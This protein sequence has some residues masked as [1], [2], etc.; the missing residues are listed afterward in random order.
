M[1]S[2]TTNSSI[3]HC[4]VINT[5]IDNADCGIVETLQTIL[6]GNFVYS[7]D[8]NEGGRSTWYGWNGNRWVNSD[9]P[10]R[11]AIMF[12]VEKYWNK[13]MEPWNTKYGGYEFEDANYKLWKRTKESA[14]NRVY[15]L[16]QAIGVNAVVTVAKS[17]ME[18]YSLEFDTNINLFGCENGVIDLD[19]ECFRPYRFDDYVSWSCGYDFKPLG[20][21]FKVLYIDKNE[22]KEK[23]VCEKD[24]TEGD[25]EEMKAV[26]NV[27][28]EIFP[29]KEMRDF[30]LFV[31]ATGLTGLA[32]EKFFVFNG[33]G[34]NGKGVTNEFM[35]S[36]F[37]DY[38]VS[39][40]AL[41]FT[42][43]SR[44]KSS[45]SA[46][47]ELAKIH[48]KP[49]AVTREP[50]KDE[51]LSN[52]FV[53]DLTGGGKMSARML[54]S[55]NSTVTKCVTCVMEC[56][57]R[58]NFKEE[59]TNAD[60][61]RVVDILFGSRF[62]SNEEELD[63]ENHVFKINA[64]LKTDKW[65]HKHRNATL[66]VLLTYLLELKNEHSYD[67]DKVRPESVKLRS[68]EYLQKSFDVHAIVTEMF[69]KRPED[70]KEVD[71]TLAAVAK[72]IFYSS[73]FRELPSHKKREYNVTKIQ[74]FFR[75][76][77]FYK[78]DV[79]RNSNKKSDCLRGWQLR[80][81]TEEEEAAT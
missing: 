65:R 64:E 3:I 49:Y 71:L 27:F 57:E 17:M 52:S 24:V 1:K 50:P 22:M 43:G 5:A 30:V 79:Y 51:L 28:A 6:P 80:Q 63:K 75:D 15:N 72:A 31:L 39:I 37:G 19:K 36:V 66:N 59:P 76:N 29:I 41:L 74:Q 32:I 16:K 40:S 48:K 35:E 25:V 10:L 14:K 7:V 11:R 46:N 58:L 42:E 9:A 68:L 73:H 44:G 60:V 34:R 12:E 67:I 70:S 56:N 18:N 62:T 13:L 53:K 26:A 45:G 69:E 21:G 4:A 38:F 47:P 2:R 55:S 23:L 78:K 54:Y 20:K 77:S 8:K 61:E 33:S 81:E